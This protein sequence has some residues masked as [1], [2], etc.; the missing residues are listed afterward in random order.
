MVYHSSECLGLP[1]ATPILFSF[2]ACRMAV[3]VF[4]LVQLQ[5]RRESKKEKCMHGLSVSVCTCLSETVF[6]NLLNGHMLLQCSDM[7]SC[8]NLQLKT[9][10]SLS[11]GGSPMSF[12]T[13]NTC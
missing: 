10:S 8:P 5:M 7:L 6:S 1:Q 12:L 9:A 3:S 4:C 2:C 13:R 11:W